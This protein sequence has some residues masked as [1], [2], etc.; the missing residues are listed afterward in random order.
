[1][2]PVRRENHWAT[3]Q[4]RKPARTSVEATNPPNQPKALLLAPGG[5]VGFPVAGDA[6]GATVAMTL[7]AA[8]TPADTS[9]VVDGDTAPETRLVVSASAKAGSLIAA[10]GVDSTS[11]NPARDTSVET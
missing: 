5:L 10:E 2:L 6:P 1:M 11:C 9:V 8:D 4:A 7:V 3:S